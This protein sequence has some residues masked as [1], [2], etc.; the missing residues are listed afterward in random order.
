M[1]RIKVRKDGPYLVTGEVELTDHEG[2]PIAPQNPE[3]FALCRC[4]H[5]RTKPF[6]DGA[7]KAVGFND[8]V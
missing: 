8:Q 7:H 1:A 2:K 5:S 6:C 4:G 3:N